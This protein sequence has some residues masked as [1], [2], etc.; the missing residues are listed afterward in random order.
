M[1][2]PNRR[3][4]ISQNVGPFTLRVGFLDNG[5]PIEFFIDGRGKSGTELD[6]WLEQIG[7]AASKIMQHEF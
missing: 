2:P 1:E 6:A 3:Q 5:Q 4:S 7:I